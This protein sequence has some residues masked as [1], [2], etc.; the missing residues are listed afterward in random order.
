MQ[1]RKG[2]PGLARAVHRTGPGNG[3]RYKEG[4]Q[5]TEFVQIISTV[6]FPIA[7]C[8]ALGWF[9]SKTIEQLRK[10]V[11]DNTRATLQ[12]MQAV[13]YLSAGGRSNDEG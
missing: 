3:A 5:M 11:E 7:A 9:I 13:Q 12:L 8:C 10:T 1:P 4:F 2:V 6:G